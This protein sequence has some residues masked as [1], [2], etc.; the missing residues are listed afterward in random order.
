MVVDFR[1]TVYLR[2]MITESCAALRPTG[3]TAK[4]Y[5]HHESAALAS[6]AAPGSGVYRELPGHRD[7]NRRVNLLRKCRRSFSPSIT[8]LTGDRIAVISL[9]WPVGMTARV[10]HVYETEFA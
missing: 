2:T 10:G 4:A 1:V 9:G 8:P 7:H 6:S 5:D 3:G